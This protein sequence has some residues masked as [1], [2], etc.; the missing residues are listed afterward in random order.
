MH[1]RILAT[2]LFGTMLPAL[3]GELDQHSATRIIEQ[4]RVYA[5]A[6]AAP[7]G[8]IAVVDAG[9][10]LV[11]LL[12]LDGSFPAAPEVAIGKARTAALFRKPTRMFEE[13]VNQGRYTMTT[14]PAVT[15]FTPLTGGVPLL[16]DGVVIGAVGVSGAAS[17]Q[18]DEDIALAAAGTAAQAAEAKP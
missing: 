16:R 13:L 3:A 6:H 11:A 18:Q 10:H 2:A 1:R 5:A 9:G 4:G 17:A 8:A 14:V 7:G 12:R 15:A